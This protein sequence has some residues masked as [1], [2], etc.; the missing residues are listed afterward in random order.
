MAIQEADEDVARP[1]EASTESEESQ[2]ADDTSESQGYASIQLDGCEFLVAQTADGRMDLRDVY[3]LDQ[4]GGVYARPV[5]SG[6]MPQEP[7][8]YVAVPWRQEFLGDLSHNKDPWI[9]D[10]KMFLIQDAP[11]EGGML[12]LENV[13]VLDA[14]SRSVARE[15]V[16]RET[17]SE[18]P[19]DNILRIRAGR[20][21]LERTDVIPTPEA[22][23]QAAEAGVIDDVD[24]EGPQD[25]A[26]SLEDDFDS[27]DIPAVD[28]A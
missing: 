5:T 6:E 28:F 24:L 12:S 3:V 19:L 18:D 10:L 27:P 15:E 2:T 26:D 1:F 13:F 8:L 22:A 4:D 14:A 21:T 20:L 16:V 7:A 23:V 9:K 25:D 17:D 11:T